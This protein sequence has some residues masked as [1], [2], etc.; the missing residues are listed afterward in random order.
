[1]PDKIVVIAEKLIAERRLLRER[2][3]AALPLRFGGGGGPSG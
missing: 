2:Q 3:A 1:V